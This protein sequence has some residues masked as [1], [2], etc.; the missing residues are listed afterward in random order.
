MA[1]SELIVSTETEKYYI[2]TIPARI[3]YYLLDWKDKNMETFIE[4]YGR[5]SLASLSKEQIKV[6]FDNATMSDLQVFS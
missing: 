5:V 6:L 4:R 2:E 1:N 3:R